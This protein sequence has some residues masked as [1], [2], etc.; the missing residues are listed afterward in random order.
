M[1]KAKNNILTDKEKAE[2]I[3]N[4]MEQFETRGEF[5]VPVEILNNIRKF[6]SIFC[7]NQ[8][9]AISLMGD[10]FKNFNCI[11]IYILLLELFL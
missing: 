1:K 6:V 9:D 7:V 5:E 8:D 2:K 11:I 4:L 10:Y 3:R